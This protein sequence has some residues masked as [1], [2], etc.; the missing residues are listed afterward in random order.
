M[1]CRCV[2]PL[3]VFHLLVKEMS[4]FVLP[5]APRAKREVS[6]LNPDFPHGRSVEEANPGDLS[7]GD[8][9][10]D[11]E[12]RRSHAGTVLLPHL[13][14][15]PTSRHDPQHSHRKSQEKW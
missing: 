1:L 10:W 13:D 7:P 14:Q 9:P 15:H 2:V 3:L 11:L 6:L 4:A 8:D 5:K 12:G